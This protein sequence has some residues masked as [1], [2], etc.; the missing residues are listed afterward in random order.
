MTVPTIDTAPRLRD[1]ARHPRRLATGGRPWPGGPQR[2]QVED[3]IAFAD[4]GITTF[5][6][7]DIYTGVEELI[8]AFRTEYCQAPRG[9]GLGADQGA[10]QAGARS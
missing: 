7:A 4:A 5:D 3:M 8:G 10:H 1:F 6:C 9:R 2:S